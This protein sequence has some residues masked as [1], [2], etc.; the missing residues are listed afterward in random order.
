MLGLPWL[1]LI[2]FAS[3]LLSFT[4]VLDDLGLLD[5]GSESGMLRRHTECSVCLWRVVDV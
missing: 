1:W 2:D 5:L 4:Y 3:L